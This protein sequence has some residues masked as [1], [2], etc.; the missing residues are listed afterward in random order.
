MRRI[1]LLIHASPRGHGGG[2]EEGRR[3]DK[4]VRVSSIRIVGGKTQ[5]EM[6]ATAKSVMCARP[7]AAH[8]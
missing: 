5:A 2:D 6:F 4:C 3:M 8:T 7:G 1:S